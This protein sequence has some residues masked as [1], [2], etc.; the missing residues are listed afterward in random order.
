M[1][2]SVSCCECSAVLCYYNINR[3]AVN[4]KSDV[5]AFWSYYDTWLWYTVHNIWYAL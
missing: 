2:R 4:E 1:A 3:I 5:C